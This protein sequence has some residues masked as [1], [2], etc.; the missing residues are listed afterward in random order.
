MIQPI[1]QRAQGSAQV[2]EQ[3]LFGS[4]D[5]NGNTHV[6]IPMRKVLFHPPFSAPSLRL[7]DCCSDRSTAHSQTYRICSRR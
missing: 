4:K 7:P 2:R 1:Y 5:G 6:D 3:R